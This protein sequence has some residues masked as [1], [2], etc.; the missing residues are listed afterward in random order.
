MVNNECSIHF[1]CYLNLNIFINNA[2]KIYFIK[3][4]LMIRQICAIIFILID[5]PIINVRD[6][7]DIRKKVVLCA[8]DK[9]KRRT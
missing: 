2:T 3:S 4:L 5:L 1:Y 7:H 6:V 9:E 8:E